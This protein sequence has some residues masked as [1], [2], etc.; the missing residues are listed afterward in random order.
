MKRKRRSFKPTMESTQ[1]RRS[2][3]KTMVGGFYLPDECWECVFKFLNDNH[4]CM[5]SLSVV[6]KQFLSITNRIRFSLTICCDHSQTLPFPPRLLRRFISLTSLDLSRFHGNLSKLLGQISSFP[7]K[8]TS[9]NLSNQS[10]IPTNGL[11]VFAKKI[12]TLTFL[13]CSK[14][15]FIYSTDLFLISD[16]FPLL[17]DL[18]LSDPIQCVRYDEVEP[19]SL[20]LFKLRKVNL[21]RHHYINDRLLF[22][23]FKKREFLEEVILRDCYRITEVGIVSAL[24]QRPTLRSL[25]ISNP[26]TRN[27]THITSHFIDSLVSLK[28]LDLS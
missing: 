11:R 19:L 26:C 6:S 4:S 18:D 28:G 3:R 17:E 24:R 16:C 13:I 1:A 10:I 27:L 9:L 12:T 20:A 15:H 7:L 22:D 25:S 8:L 23:L 21:S 2:K 14:V 5:T